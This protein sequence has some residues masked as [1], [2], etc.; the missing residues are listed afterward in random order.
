MP[1][2]QRLEF[3][4]RYKLKDTMI[5]MVILAGIFGIVFT[6]QNN[7]ARL[8]RVIIHGVSFDEY[9]Q[10]SIRLGYD[11]ENKGANNEQVAI[12]A[13]IYDDKDLEI[14]SIMFLADIKA[15]S[16]VYQT[17]II[18]KL[19]RPLMEGEKPHRATLEI[20]ERGFLQY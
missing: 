15:H 11:I 4:K 7:K 3:P 20:Q 19:N 13:L 12:L 9:D 6:S 1:I 8:Q 14:A 5:L 2:V 10:Q 17:K 16:R 18:D